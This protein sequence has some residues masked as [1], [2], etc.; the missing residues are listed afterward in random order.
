MKANPEKS[1]SRKSGLRFGASD[2]ANS[3]PL[4][5]CLK[6]VMPEARLIKRVPSAMPGL[7][8]DNK[9]DIALVPVGALVGDRQLDRIP[10]VGVCA[11]TVVRS[12][13]IKLHKPLKQVV[14]VRMDAA[15]RTSNALARILLTQRYGLKVEMV[16][17]S[18]PGP[19]DAEVMIGDRALRS[20]PARCGDLDMAKEW[21]AMTGLPFVFAV[22]ACRAGDPRKAEYTRMVRRVCDAGVAAL[23]EIIAVES[24][25]L[26]LSRKR[27]EEYFSKCIHYKLGRRETQA[28]A[29]FS[30]ML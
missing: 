6:Q 24:C 15:S 13:L 11:K 12:V 5:Y 19:I 18:E 4:L 8:H 28:I 27:C 17:P 26:G 1:Q 3:V 7:L 10:G 14:R 20:E 23:P 9:V 21:K 16:N 2:Y 29:L 25:R 22:W 30:S